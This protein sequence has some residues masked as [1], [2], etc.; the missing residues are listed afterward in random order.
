MLRADSA[1]LGMVHLWRTPDDQDYDDDPPNE[2]VTVRFVH[3][4]GPFVPVAICGWSKQVYEGVVELD[5][6]I[7]TPGMPGD[8]Y[9]ILWGEIKRAVL[10]GAQPADKVAMTLRLNAAG[11]T[12]IDS[13]QP[14]VALDD[15]GVAVGSIA[16]RVQYE[17]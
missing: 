4:P 14:P 16:L 1:L 9:T 12:D 8:N 15:N 6:E 5:L 10:G 13:F 3:R 11:I 7:H 2:V 17:R